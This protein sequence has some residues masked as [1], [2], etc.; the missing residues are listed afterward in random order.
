MREVVN[1]LSK[2]DTNDKFMTWLTTVTSHQPYGES[3]YGNKYL[4]LF[5]DSKYD[6]YDIKLKR[7]MSKL[8]VLDDGLGILLNGLE[9]Q[10]KLDNTVIVLYGDHYPYGLSNNILKEALPYSIDV[11]YENERVP[12]VIWSEE[13][14]GTTFTQYTSY[15]NIL[16]TIANL[17]NLEYDSRYYVGSDLF[18]NEYQ[19]LVVFADGSWKN[20]FA[21]YNAS[22]S[23]ITYF[24]NKQYSI[25]DLIQINET[26]EN[27]IKYSNLAIQ[28]DYFNYLFKKMQN[29]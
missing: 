5:E 22:T 26:V 11:K 2:Y 9:K 7:Y 18:S 4:Y 27:K 8:K 14:E 19:S 17:F 13:T 21:F 10:G 28:H 29:Y 6:N 12:F 15:V 3:L 20:E 25:S 24:K 16:P 1:I 23:D